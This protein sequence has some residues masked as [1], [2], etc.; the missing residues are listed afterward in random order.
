MSIKPSEI[1]VKFLGCEFTIKNMSYKLALLLAAAI[2]IVALSISFSFVKGWSTISA[3]FEK[4]T[5]QMEKEIIED[6][7]GGSH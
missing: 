2:L 1:N 3:E 5:K 7:A 4:K 6:S